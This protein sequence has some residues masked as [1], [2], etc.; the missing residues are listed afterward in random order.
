MSET[1]PNFSELEPMTR[2]QVLIAMGVTAFVL[3]LVAR[4]WMSLGNVSILPIQ[5]SWINLGWGIALGLGIT[6]ASAVVYQV[7]PS[8]RLAA[9]QYLKIVLKP[10]IWADLIWLGLLPGLSEEL[11]FRG[12]MLAALGLNITAV[13]I[14][15]LCFGVLHLGGRQQ[16]P[17]VIWASSVGA[18]L[19]LTALYTQSLL[20]PVIAHIVTNLMAG[21]IWKLRHPQST[22]VE[23]P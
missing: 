7:W 18:V 13:I 3:L 1:P 22:A 17:Y 5:G 14:S 8:Y 16:W 6:L 4:I 15:S 2:P 10:L 11:L 23:E 9:N 12:V 20:I 19:G 21:I